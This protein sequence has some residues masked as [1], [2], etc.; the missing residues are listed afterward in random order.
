[1]HITSLFSTSTPVPRAYRSN[2]LNL[3][4]DIGW[5]GLL[6]GSSMA[7]LAVYATRL[8]ASGLQVGLLSAMPAVV[9]LALALPAGQWLAGRQTHKAVFWSSVLFRLGYLFWIPLPWFFGGQGQ[10][11]A[12]II[13]GLLQAIPGTGLVVGFNAVF[14]EAVPA[15]WRA[16]VAGGRNMVFSITYILTSLACGWLLDNLAFPAGYQVVFAIGFVGAAMSSY[17]LYRL[18]P[19]EDRDPSRPEPE[20]AAKPG[21][22][23]QR[24]TGRS[25]GSILRMDIWQ[26]PF[27]ST[28]LV[29]LA[30]HL[31]Q[32]LAIPIFPLYMVRTLRLGDQ[33]IGAGTAIFYLAV[34]IGSSQLNRLSRRYGHQRITAIGAVGLCLYPLLLALSRGFGLFVIANII[35]GLNWSMLGGALPNYLLEK[36]P[37]DDRTPHLAWY[38]IILNTAILTG[39]LVG[40]LIADL[41]GLGA[42]LLLFAMLRALSGLLIARWG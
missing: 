18:R 33:Q 5:F 42:A 26:T 3:Y 31:A 10:I 32:Y 7:F 17:H 8:G 15:R 4:L 39:S 13:L 23:W 29:L 41:A 40:P 27:R 21:R 12:F 22:L 34:L 11:Q 2:F 16:Y 37:E 28:L 6:S 30:Y 35:G 36:V 38:N 19:L 1:M 14:A 24:L 9:N 25:W 20:P